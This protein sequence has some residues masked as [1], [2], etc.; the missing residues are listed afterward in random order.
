MIFQV[1][2]EVDGELVG[3]A[4]GALPSAR[5]LMDGYTLEVTRVATNG[6]PNACS[7]LYAASA[8]AARALGYRRCVT[9]TLESEKGTALKAAGWKV[10]EE[11]R[12]CNQDGWRN[13]IGK[14]REIVNLF[15]ER[16]IP[17]EDKRRWWKECG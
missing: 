4:V 11:I 13:R 17:S 6:Y 7:M 5:A 15:G 3:V 16:T 10:D 1:G 8:N 9:Y 14:R 12:K 2:V